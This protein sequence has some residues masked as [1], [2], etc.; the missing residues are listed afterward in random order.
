MQLAQIERG[1]ASVRGGGSELLVLRQGAILAFAAEELF[2]IA[3]GSV[4]PL[5]VCVVNRIVVGRLRARP[6][7]LLLHPQF[8]FRF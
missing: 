6:K 3:P 2:L 1:N 5:E 7:R 4:V 8:M